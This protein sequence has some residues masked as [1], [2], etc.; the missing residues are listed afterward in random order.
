MKPISGPRSGA[1]TLVELL[2]TIV[3][4]ALI[5]AIL[6]PGMRQPIGRSSRINCT[7]NLKQM[8]IAFRTWALDNNDQFPMQVALTNTGPLE[9]RNLSEAYVYFQAMSNELST[10]KI[11]KCPNDTE[12]V[13]ATNF[14]TDF[15]NQKLSYFVGLDVSGESPGSF[16]SG[17]RN[18]TNALGM[19]GSILTLVTNLPVAWTEGL[20]EKQGNI[21]FA[22]ARVQ[23]LS[24]RGLQTALVSSGLA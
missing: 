22:D 11:L 6:L 13:W 9:S 16:L 12:R 8:G 24:T 23:G 15:S 17:D 19:K 21:L 3:I 4:L 10:P 5:I 18:L 1:F 2:I 7:N 14:T 20:H